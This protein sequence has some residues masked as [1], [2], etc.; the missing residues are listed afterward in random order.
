METN[1]YLCS[2]EKEFNVTGAC[3]PHEHYMADTSAK[4]KAITRLVE[5]GKYFTINRPRQYGKT[6]M[7]FALAN[8][9]KQTGEYVVFRT[10]FE[11]VGDDAFLKEQSF[12]TLFLDLLLSEA[13][14]WGHTELATLLSEAMSDTVSLRQLSKKITE[15]AIKADKKLV[16]LIDEV[17]KSSNN[18]LFISFLGMLRDKYL[19]RQQSPTFHSVVLTGVHDVKSLKLKLRPDEEKKFNSPWNIAADFK[20]D[21]NLQPTEIVPMLEEYTVDRGVRV[22]TLAVAD[23]LFYYTSGYPFLVSKICKIFDEELL[24]EKAEKTWTTHDVDVAARQLV[25]ETNTNFDELSKNLDNN[26]DLYRLTQSIAIDSEQYPFN[27]NNPTAQ[28][29]ILYGIFANRNGLAIHNRI[30]QEVITNK[31]MFLMQFENRT[32]LQRYDTA[33]GLP[34]NRLDIQKVLLKFQ[35]LMRY[36]HHKENGKLLEREARL[37]FLAFLSP[38]LNSHGYALKEPQTS[39][40]KRLDVLVTYYQH[41]YVIELKLWYGQTAHEAGLNQLADYLD[42]LGLDEGFL[43]IFDPRAKKEWKSEPILHKGKRIFAVWV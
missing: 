42:R 24:A 5:Q 27:P 9:L 32:L 41:R 28:L 20:V 23:R 18:Q 4:F 2:M 7:L 43:L 38:I 34:G 19:L 33:F 13:E 8:A 29:G 3:F 31:M 21:M 6:T 37:V 17:D 12:C 36:E 35:E 40:E 15:L 14:T 22:D 16:L 10:S 26:P 39:E 25:K 1:D 11:G 30:Y